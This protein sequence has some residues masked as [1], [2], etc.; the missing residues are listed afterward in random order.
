M[1]HFGIYF[2]ELSYSFID[3]RFNAVGIKRNGLF[4]FSYYY[5]KQ[6]KFDAQKDYHY[7]IK[8]VFAY[9]EEHD[10]EFQRVEI[11]TD[12]TEDHGILEPYIYYLYYHHIAPGTY[13]TKEMT[14]HLDK[15]YFMPVS[16]APLLEATPIFVFPYGTQGNAYKV[17]QKGPGVYQVIQ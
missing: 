11:N 13:D 16:V 3:I 15:Y 1:V 6:Y 4:I 12:V 5:F 7:G 10:S 2:C 17:Y 8:E 14:T 9:L